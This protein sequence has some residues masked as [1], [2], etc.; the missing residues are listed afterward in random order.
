MAGR[1][2]DQRK[3]RR[4]KRIVAVF[5]FLVLTMFA[6]GSGAVYAYTH[7]LNEQ[8]ST[9]I[10]DAFRNS[11]SDADV[12]AGDPFYALLLGVDSDENRISGTEAGLY[13]GDHFRSDTIILARVDPKQKQVT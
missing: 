6:L 8:L 5:A 12:V 1:Y 2:R 10:D 13:E 11:L 3:K 9:G 4:R 7:Y